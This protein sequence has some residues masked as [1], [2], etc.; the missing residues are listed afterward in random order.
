MVRFCNFCM[1]KL[2]NTVSVCPN[3]GEHNR[4][5][6]LPHH[7]K[8]GTVLNNRYYVGNSIGEGGFGITY[9]GYDIK[10]D[11]KVAIKEF[12]PNGWV[13]RSENTLSPRVSKNPNNHG[14]D[15]FD[16]GKKRFL[17]EARILA[18]F[19]NESGVVKVRDVFEE[20]NTVYII[21]EYLD[22]IT[23]KEYLQQKG[24]LTPGETMTLLM[25]IMKSLKNVHNQGLLHR[26][27]SPDNI[28]LVDDRVILLDFGAARQIS[29]HENRS[30]S[31]VLK[32]GYAP[33]E[34]YTS[35]GQQGPWTDIYALSAT[36]YKCITGQ[37]PEEALERMQFDELKKPSELNIPISEQ[38]EASLMRGLGIYPKDR[39]QNMD[40]FIMSLRGVDVEYE[41]N[42]QKPQGVYTIPMFD[43]EN[44]YSKSQKESFHSNRRPQHESNKYESQESKLYGYVPRK[45]INGL[46]SEEKPNLNQ[47]VSKVILENEEKRI[48]KKSKKS[49]VVKITGIVMGGIVI[50]CIIIPLL[51]NG[52]MEL[53]EWNLF[54]EEPVNGSTIT[55]IVEPYS[56][57]VTLNQVEYDLPC[58]FEYF[59]YSGWNVAE[60]LGYTIDTELQPN[61]I[62]LVGI[63][64]DNQKIILGVLNQGDNPAQLIE[65]RVV[66]IWLFDDMDVDWV[67]AGQITKNSTRED[68]VNLFGEPTMCSSDDNLEYLWYEQEI[69]NKYTAISF[70][71]NKSKQ[72]TSMNIQLYKE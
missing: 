23:L 13:N 65:C 9:V 25:P 26:D 29:A 44:Q 66:G 7:L 43:V 70:T 5:S 53:I 10:L 61:E 17:D 12:F 33:Q 72:T 42:V 64:K 4:T 16:K 67:Y 50:V 35:K 52:V 27:I 56:C 39:C 22:G 6:S 58:P 37:V 51:W 30:L 14:A 48:K 62:N 18:K 59:F 41:V 19:D 1:T 11:I 47:S 40:D 24:T 46:H 71:V 57:T 54:K 36:M 60:E 34:Q 69:N 3:C 63:E 15:F 20:N 32:P 21:M 55:E 68:I 49:K 38:L 2:N 8:A 28:M 31:I 45:D